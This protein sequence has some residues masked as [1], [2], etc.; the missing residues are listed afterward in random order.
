LEVGKMSTRAEIEI[1]DGGVYK[2]YRHYDGYPDAVIAD[3]KKALEITG[4]HDAEYFL[5]N[6]IFLAKWNFWKQG[7]D[8][9][10]GYGVMMP[11]EEYADTDYQYRLWWEKGKV[12][13]EIWEKD[14]DRKELIFKG[15]LDE[16]YEKLVREFKDGCHIREA[17]SSK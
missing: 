10:M 3:L 2:I 6:F 8:W 7:V 5:A 14:W 11:H 17:P 13:V 4:Y 9:E 1:I 16:A 15:T 12:Y